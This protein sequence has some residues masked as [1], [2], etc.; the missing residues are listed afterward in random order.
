MSAT[1]FDQVFVLLNGLRFNVFLSLK[2]NLFAKK[3][4]NIIKTR[5]ISIKREIEQL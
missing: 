2:A 3:E 4:K 5:V 1:I